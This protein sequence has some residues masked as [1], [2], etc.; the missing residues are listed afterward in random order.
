[1]SRGTRDSGLSHATAEAESRAAKAR[2]IER[3]LALDEGSGPCRVLEVGTGSGGIAHYFGA[4]PAGRYQVDAVDVI[5]GRKVLD[6]FRFA[7]VGGTALPY[8]DSTFD[9]VISNH[10]LEHVGNLSAQREHLA[11]L[12]R[13]MADDAIGY[14]AVPNRWMLVEPH[15]RLAFLSWLPRHW[16]TRYL[17]WRTGNAAA[18]Y[19]C[20]PLALPELESLLRD[21]GL[22]FEDRAADAIRAL[23]DTDPAAGLAVRVLA[24][25][26]AVIIWQFRRIVPT[27]VHTFVKAGRSVGDENRT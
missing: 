23:R 21:A 13:V 20:E 11:E 3:L 14:L 5:D 18:I 6:G 12:A 16:R 17:R 19:D 15:Y 26:P 27:L 1:M 25:L 8:S 24:R 4:H 7:V 9:V 10:V 2:K 22:R